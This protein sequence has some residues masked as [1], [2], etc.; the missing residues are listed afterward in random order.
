MFAQS[1]GHRPNVLSSLGL[2]AEPMCNVMRE[3][4]G[5]TVL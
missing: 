3:A 2:D 1:L 4:V 5:L